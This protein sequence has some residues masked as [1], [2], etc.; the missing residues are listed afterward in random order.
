MN[1]VVDTKQD[2]L[3]FWGGEHLHR[4]L[5]WSGDRYSIVCFNCDWTCHDRFGLHWV[6]EPTE[7]IRAQPY[8]KPRI[9]S[10]TP[11]SGPERERID[12]C[13]K[14]LLDELGK[15]KFN[16]TENLAAAAARK[17]SKYTLRA[18][19]LLFGKIVKAFKRKERSD[20]SATLAYPLLDALV[21]MYVDARVPGASKRYSAYLVAK[22]S[23]CAWHRDRYNVGPSLLMAFGDYEDGELEVC[24]ER[25]MT[26]QCH[27]CRT[28]GRPVRKCRDGF[29]H[30]GPNWILYKHAERKCVRPHSPDL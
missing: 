2:A 26:M 21:R 18:E 27:E 20:S 9:A 19:T 22:N 29:G 13:E 25:M 6:D 4:T 3:E 17:Q 23:H 30:T 16:V 28:L 8:F 11:D 12:A 7:D 15:A 1:I 14:Q 5:E 24:P 10:Q